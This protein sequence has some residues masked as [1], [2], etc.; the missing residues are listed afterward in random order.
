MML[1]VLMVSVLITATCA[2]EADFDFDDLANLG[3]TLNKQYVETTC[4]GKPDC[5]CSAGSLASGGSGL[6]LGACCSKCNGGMCIDIFCMSYLLNQVK[7]TTNPDSPVM[8]PW[9]A[10][11]RHSA[12]IT[13][14]VRTAR[15][16]AINPVI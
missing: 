9:F 10:P 6:G 5:D 11:C 4:R 16:C 14:L 15:S 2:C 1:K 13:A 8:A 12:G 7:I 3:N